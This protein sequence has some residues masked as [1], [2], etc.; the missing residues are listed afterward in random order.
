MDAWQAA[1][2][3]F[4]Y[5]RVTV[6]HL[7]ASI[8]PPQYAEMRE[9]P[10]RACH[11]CFAHTELW[12][13]HRRAEQTGSTV[14]YNGY[15]MARFALAV[16]L[17]AGVFGGYHAYQSF[18]SPLLSA[19]DAANDVG[20]AY[21]DPY[22][23]IIRSISSEADDGPVHE[24]MYSMTVIGNF[25]KGRT[26]AH[27]LEFSAMASRHSAWGLWAGN[28]LPSH[29]ARR[30]WFANQVPLRLTSENR[31]YPAKGSTR[32]PPLGGHTRISV[33]HWHHSGG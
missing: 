3:E 5:V 17:L 19:Q 16:L 22:P 7:R 32:T 10:S 2:S 6:D 14:Q 29:T 1:L 9:R 12:A 21:G 13:G 18:A 20:A 28:T 30:A 23:R 11:L 8:E 26:T 31:G 27:Y 25:H 15:T 4:G 33:L 24:P